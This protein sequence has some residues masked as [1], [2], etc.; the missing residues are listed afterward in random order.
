MTPR[1]TEWLFRISCVPAL[2]ALPLV[3][4]IGLRKVRERSLTWSAPDSPMNSIASVDRTRNKKGPLQLRLAPLL[5]LVCLHWAGSSAVGADPHL[6]EWKVEGVRRQALVHV[7]GKNPPGQPAPV[8]FAF[9]GHGGSMQ[10][11]RRSF[12]LH[13][14]W[15]EAVV[16]YPQGL[17]TPGQLTDPEG[18]RAGW[19]HAAGAQDDRDLKF[20]DS[21]LASLQAEQAVDPARVFV[22]GHSNGGGFTYLLWATRGDK[23]AAVAPSAAA[24]SP[25]NFLRLRPKPVM[26]LAGENDLLVRFAW[27]EHTMNALR[28]LNGCRE[29]RPWDDE[30]GCTWYASETGTP[31]VTFI[32]RGGHRFP[33]EGPRL[34]VKF[35]QEASRP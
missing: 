3:C 30:S 24:T 26:H 25:G 14:L 9:H 4:A 33:A 22:T 32:H 5:L 34:I 13:T 1:K 16:V 11:A 35:F 21:M 27:Q 23:L 15:P 31:V 10:N 28:R 20:F 8:V 7:P 6:R 17:K 12:H 2:L 19:Q 18:R 29:G